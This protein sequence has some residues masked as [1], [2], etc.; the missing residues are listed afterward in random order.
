MVGTLIGQAVDIVHLLLGQRLGGRVL[1][2]I[3]LVGVFFCQAFA[4]EGI[5]IAVL[6]IEAFGIAFPVLPHRG[7]RRQKHRVIDILF[8][9]HL[10]DRAFHKGDILSRK[11]AVQSLR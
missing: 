7:I 4:V 10:A 6:G 3:D 11:A 8:P 1:H 9:A 2:H 5:R